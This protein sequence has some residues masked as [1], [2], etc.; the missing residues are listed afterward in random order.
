[1]T[2]N[3]EDKQELNLR[4][5]IAKY[6]KKGQA[7]KARR[8]LIKAIE[9]GRNG[10]LKKILRSN[11]EDAI[12][13]SDEIE[14]RDNVDQLIKFYSILELA[15]LTGYVSQ[16]LPEPLQQEIIK[17]L[18]NKHVAA[19]Y[20]Q[21]YPDLLPQLLYE[22]IDAR[23]MQEP[24]GDSSDFIKLLI[25]N[26]MIDN[27]V[28]NFLWL[29]DSGSFGDYDL[30]EFKKTLTNVD[31]I[32]SI[33]EGDA[34][35]KTEQEVFWGL[36]GYLNYI[37]HFDQLLKKVSKNSLMESA[38][39]HF[40]GYWF[41][42]INKGVKRSLVRCVSLLA[43]SSKKAMLATNLENRGAGEEKLQDIEGQLER[44]IVSVNSVTNAGHGKELKKYHSSI[45]KARIKKQLQLDMDFFV[46]AFLNQGSFK[47]LHTQTD[48]RYPAVV[49]FI[50]KRYPEMV[51]SGVNIDRKSSRISFLNLAFKNTANGSFLFFHLTNNSLSMVVVEKV[52][53]QLYA[54]LGSINRKEDTN[55]PVCAIVDLDYQIQYALPKGSNDNLL[56]KYEDSLPDIEDMKRYLVEND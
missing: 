14:F 21:F 49:D 43:E 37:E 4:S 40:Q 44:F 41:E 35:F 9:E 6:C 52:R 48:P 7:A 13:D 34:D 27:N 56:A 28:T 38:F 53:D 10:Y 46:G 50:N 8:N 1:M 19:Y 5:L 3:F 2:M 12:D 24:I 17:I 23:K 39:W 45:I 47:M 55:L 36:L 26:G 31:E 20:E 16:P 33:L 30:D 32:Q 29:L 18:G 51:F 11:E 22:A 15:I 25:V 54:F 42:R